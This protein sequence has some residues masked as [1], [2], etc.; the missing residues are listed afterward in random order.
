MKSQ[1]LYLMCVKNNGLSDHDMQL[2]SSSDRKKLSRGENGKFW[3]ARKEREKFTVALTGGAFDILH[4]GHLLTLKEAKKQADLLVVV[5]AT[6]ERVK[7]MKKRPPIHSCEQRTEMVSAIRWVDL[8][9]AGSQDIMESF[10]RVRPDVVVF[11]YDQQPMKL[12]VPVKVVHL[13]DIVFNEKLAK[14]SKILK[15]LGI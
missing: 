4:M 7:E 15:K 10:Y 6:D 11:G 12:P 14:T 3:L 5:V 9:I 1:E 13:K 8:A 2:L